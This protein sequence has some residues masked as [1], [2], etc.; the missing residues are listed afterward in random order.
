M[1]DCDQQSIMEFLMHDKKMLKGQMYFILPL[2]IGKVKRFPIQ[3]M[4]LIKEV[5]NE[6]VN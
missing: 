4:N 6:I 1:N 2:R 5:L 3:D